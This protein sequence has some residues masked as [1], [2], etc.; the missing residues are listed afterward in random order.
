MTF[1][2]PKMYK[3]AYRGCSLSATKCHSLHPS[4]RIVHRYPSHYW[5]MGS[6]SE[7]GGLR[8]ARLDALTSIVPLVFMLA[9]RFQ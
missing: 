5:P 1:A 4:L 2:N 9:W 7:D 6:Y 8:Y 3:G